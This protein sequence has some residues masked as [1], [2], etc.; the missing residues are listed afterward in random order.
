MKKLYIIIALSVMSV[1]T[2]KAQD[3]STILTAGDSPQ[4]NMLN[5]GYMTNSSFVGIPLFSNLAFKV[6]NSFSL[7]DIVKNKKIILSNIPDDS[8]VNLGLNLDVINFGVK[9]KEKN[10]ITVSTSVKADV[11]IMYPTGIFNFIQDNSITQSN[12]YDVN[13][14][15]AATVWGEV[16][17]GYTRVID[18]NWSVGGKVKHL[19]GV[20][21]GSSNKTNLQIDKTSIDSYTI[22]S[23]IDV[24]I[25]GYDINGGDFYYDDIINNR[26]WAFDIGVHYKSNDNRWSAGFSVLD[27]GYIKWNT[28]SQIKSVDSN[29]SYVFSGFEDLETVLDGGDMTSAV[30]DL[31]DSITTVLEFDTTSVK[32]NK[33]VPTTIHL[34]GRYDIDENGRHSV[35]GNFLAKISNGSLYDYSTTVGYTYSSKSKNFRFMGSLINRKYDPISLGLGILGESN[36]F[37]FYMMSETSMAGLV[38]LANTQNFGFRLGL[39]ILIGKNKYKSK[40]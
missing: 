6:T 26:G 11:D 27:I 12:S 2:L 37:Q 31:I 16:A 24:L 17:L 25:G 39:N 29:K 23:D 3:Y 32:F 38:N 15:S 19:V 9:F 10:L 30:D 20:V 7:N 4:A 22:K 8:H 33:M 21:G 35:S 14:K 34:G 18:D 40:G 13:F 5:P 1:L 28:G 36:G